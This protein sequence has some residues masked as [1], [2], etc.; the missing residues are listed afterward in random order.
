MSRARFLP[1]LGLLLAALVGSPARAFVLSRAEL[2]GDWSLVRWPDS[3]RSV[4]YL[5]NDRPLDLLPNLAAGSD[6]VTA[7]QA[8]MQAWAIAPVRFSLSDTTTSVTDGVVDGRNVISFADTPGNR[9]MTAGNHVAVTGVWFQ[10]SGSEW[11]IDEVDTVFNPRERFA[12]D[13]SADAF[14]VQG[15]LTHELGHALGI[16][17]SA[18]TA[19]TMY[20]FTDH[21]RLAPRTLDPDD[22]AAMRALYGVPDPDA[23][24]IAGQVVTTAGDPVLGAHV[25]A[26]NRDG[27]VLIG[28]LADRDGSFTLPSLPAGD[29]QV[30]AEPLIGNTSPANYGR[31]Y[32]EAL[33][34][35]RPAFAGGDPTA[36]PVTVTAGQTTTLD[37]ISVDPEGATI[38]FLAIGWSQTG[39]SFRLDSP[40]APPV[41]G[42][43]S[44]YLVVIGDNL[45]AVPDDGFRFSGPDLELDSSQVLRGTL[46]GHAVAI[47]PLRVHRGA[48]PGPRNLTMD[49]GT[50]QAVYT[51]AV[52]VEASSQ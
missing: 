15:V 14:D 46:Q 25:V 11:N 31:Y 9:D 30:Y 24:T 13:G 47:L 33:T 44:T 2:N 3:T 27:V 41:H 8:A 28:A 1:A 39:R 32:R 23:G 51:G 48:P 19:V 49:T 50:E 12:T 18:I 37:P 43:A 21:G 26:T 4:R 38:G 52:V 17:H 40:F 5:M 22:V 16:N 20:P 29:Y 34:T 35:F 10:S 7:V 45:D 36:T 6:P 42:G